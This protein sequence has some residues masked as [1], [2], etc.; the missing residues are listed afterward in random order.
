VQRSGSFYFAIHVISFTFQNGI[1]STA[2]IIILYEFVWKPRLSK[3][4]ASQITTQLLGELN[5]FFKTVFHHKE[6]SEKP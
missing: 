1:I 5:Q 4:P 2:R 3:D 6:T